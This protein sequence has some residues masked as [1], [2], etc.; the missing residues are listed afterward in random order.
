MKYIIKIFYSPEKTFKEVKEKNVKPLVPLL[1]LILFSVIINLLYV[2]FIIYPK[3]LEIIE[4]QNLP[5]EALERASKFLSR[6]FL[7]IQTLI[8]TLIFF[9]I[10]ILFISLVYHLAIPLLGGES[11][12]EHAFLYVTYSKFV[13]VLSHYIKFP[14]SFFKKNV[15][16]Q[17][18]LAI[19]FPFLK[20]K[21]FFLYLLLTQFDIFTIYSL[22]V[23]S[24]GMQTF[25]N[26]P[27]KRSLILVYS[28]WLL[29]AVVISILGI[30]GERKFTF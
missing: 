26:V 11:K 24:C 23:I 28:L 17:T 9:P 5:P 22:Y 10:T 27:K 1:I 19:F 30:K 20:D 2:N 18:D 8:G 3:R 21:I 25:S 14:I 13:N 12:F 16:V 4:M 29:V 15:I 6:E 7:N